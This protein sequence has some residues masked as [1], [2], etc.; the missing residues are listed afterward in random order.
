MPT[1]PDTLASSP[2]DPVQH[3]WAG[4][5][6]P[7]RGVKSL[8]RDAA[9]PDAEAG[10]LLAYGNGRSYS[11]VCLNPQNTLLAT[12]RLDHF[13]QFDAQTGT[14][15]CEAGLLLG[16]VLAVTLPQGWFLPVLPG[17]R[18]ATV[19]GAIANDVHGKNH[20]QAG[21]FGHQVRALS[22]RRSDGEVQQLHPGDQRFAASVGGLGLTGLI[23]AAELSLRRVGGPMLEEHAEVFGNLDEGL[24]LL[25]QASE[26]T[27]YAAAWL[28]CLPRREGQGRGLLLSANHCD[29]E[30]DATGLGRAPRLGMAGLP[31]LPLINRLSARAFNA[32]YFSAARRRP[33]LARVHCLPFLFT[34][35]ALGDW[36][37][38]Y[39]RRGL[40]QYQCV[41]PPEAAATALRDVLASVADSE[42]TCALAVLKRFGEREAA[43]MLSFPRTGFTLALDFP[44]RGER[45]LN[46]F[47]RL[48]A[49]VRGAGGALY[50]AKDAR[51]PAAMFRHSFPRA[52]AFAEHVDP[53]FS[54]G[55]WR[56]VWP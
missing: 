32:L 36:N 7:H 43:G 51:M 15:H 48:D 54:S 29:G 9:L 28:D 24:A 53:G 18:Y 26:R 39:G 10:S 27:E 20:C 35:D 1:D 52:E 21:S 14:L 4:L 33:T 8:W 12:R 23:S 5:S 19:G 2:T 3:C 11:D 47:T 56:R 49:I 44:N 42:E 22:L 16:E 38:L 34:L 6:A 13:L 25:Q 17:T 40:R 55:F 31:R 46:L 45:L 50:P 41:V 37:R 30:G